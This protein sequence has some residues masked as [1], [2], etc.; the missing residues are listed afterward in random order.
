VVGVEGNSTGHF[1]GLIRRQTGYAIPHLVP[2][3]DGLPFTA[4][5]ILAGL[6]RAGLI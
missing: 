2:R 1:A 5:F 3:Y 4:D 6:A